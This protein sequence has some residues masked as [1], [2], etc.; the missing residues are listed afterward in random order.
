MGCDGDMF[1]LPSSVAS[2]TFTKRFSF[3]TDQTVPRLSAFITQQNKDA[4]LNFKP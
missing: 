2:L 3:I 1:L 4:C